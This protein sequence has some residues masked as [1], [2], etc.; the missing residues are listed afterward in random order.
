L[1]AGWFHSHPHITVLPSHV[2]VNTQ[3]MYQLLE[4]GFVG[5][6]FSVFNR[7]AATKGHSV[8]AT[9]FQALPAGAPGAA[10]AP[11]PGR[12]AS[13]ELGGSGSGAGSGDLGRIDS[14]TRDAIRAATAAGGGVTGSVPAA[15][16]AAAVVPR[17]MGWAGALHRTST[18]RR[19]LGASQWARPAAGVSHRLCLTTS[20]PAPPESLAGGGG[21]GDAYVRKEVP[22]SIAPA[23]SSAGARMADFAAV[24]AL[25]LKE[26]Q[27]AHEQ[28]RAAGAGAGAR[29]ALGG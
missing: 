1:P 28:R 17:R 21:R 11:P 10:A 26:E 3:A 6:I 15:A 23:G 13:G 7:D 4:P 19:R 2:D 5:L 22:L 20:P 25:L 24:Q 12:G 18:R 29:C 27:Q 9:A 14:E 8:S 16:A